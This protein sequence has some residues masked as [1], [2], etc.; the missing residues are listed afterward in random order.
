MTVRE[1]IDRLRDLAEASVSPDEFMTA[2]VVAE[3]GYQLFDVRRE[4]TDLR[5][6][7]SGRP[8]VTLNLRRSDE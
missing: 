2:T 6:T 7:P 1:L 3:H 8:V 5:F 4:I